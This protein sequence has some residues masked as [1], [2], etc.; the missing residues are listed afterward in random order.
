MKRLFLRRLLVLVLLQGAWGLAQALPLTYSFDLGAA[1]SG[2]FSIKPN[3]AAPKVEAIELSAFEWDITGVG[4]FDLAD[5]S[6]FS[7]GRWSAV[8]GLQPNASGLLSL[9]FALKTNTR[10]DTGV[11]CAICIVAAQVAP[12]GV[13]NNQAAARTVVRAAGS[14]CGTSG[15]CQR[16]TARLGVVP[17]PASWPLVA[18]ALA[19]G[20]WFGRRPEPGQARG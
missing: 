20:P 17:E 9:G 13:V 4:A 3:A 15:V 19:M 1:G 6:V 18:L 8:N 11:A 7:F 2:S 10:S 14:P 5:L 12:S 16:L